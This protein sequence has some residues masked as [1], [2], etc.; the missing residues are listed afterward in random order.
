MLHET[1]ALYQSIIKLYFLA[2]D[3]S[4][5]TLTCYEC[6]LDIRSSFKCSEVPFNTQY[7]RIRRNAKQYLVRQAAA[8]AAAEGDAEA[9]EAMGLIDMGF[10]IWEKEKEREIGRWLTAQKRM[11]R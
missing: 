11:N 4:I 3:R 1:P 7:K 8:Q 10:E 2:F 5:G 6:V 9:A